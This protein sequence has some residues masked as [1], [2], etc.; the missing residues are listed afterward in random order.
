MKVNVID[1]SAKI[2]N[3]TASECMHW[4]STHETYPDFLTESDITELQQFQYR[5]NRKDMV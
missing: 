4:K 1:I 5:Q 3:M 2:E